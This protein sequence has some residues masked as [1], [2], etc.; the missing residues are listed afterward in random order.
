MASEPRDLI[1]IKSVVEFGYRNLSDCTMFDTKNYT[2][3]ELSLGRLACSFTAVQL[4]LSLDQLGQW[5]G[6]EYVSV[7]QFTTLLQ[8]LSCESFFDPWNDGC[9]KSF[10][11]SRDEFQHVSSLTAMAIIERPRH[12][13]TRGETAQ[14]HES[15]C[16]CVCS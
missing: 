6:Y 2:L 1:L 14:G 9:F 8:N 11:L 3:A 15:A 10:A 12:L 4:M 7:R 5:N 13:T 16:L